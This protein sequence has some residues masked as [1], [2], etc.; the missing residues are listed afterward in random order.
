MR[1]LTRVPI[2]WPADDAGRALTPYIKR[3]VHRPC[4]DSWEFRD[5]VAE[6]ATRTKADEFGKARTLALGRCVGAWA[7]DS[8]DMSFS[9]GSIF[10]AR[11]AMIF[12][13]LLGPDVDACEIR[14]RSPNVEEILAHIRRGGLAPDSRHFLPRRGATPDL[15]IECGKA[16]DSTL[17]VE[18]TSEHKYG[19]NLTCFLRLDDLAMLG[20]PS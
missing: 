13:S 19:I 7:Y 20:S 18:F 14:G 8:G 6:M 17:K 10:L 4:W 12:K 15:K 16:E 2:F 9:R 3:A 5:F 1:G 11:S